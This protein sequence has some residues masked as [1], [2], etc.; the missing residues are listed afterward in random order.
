[1]SRSAVASN[2]GQCA[3]KAHQDNMFVQCLHPK[4]AVTGVLLKCKIQHTQARLKRVTCARWVRLVYVRRASLS[5][6]VSCAFGLKMFLNMSNMLK[7]FL[8]VRRVPGVW[9]IRFEYV[10]R[11]LQARYMPPI[12]RK[13]WVY[14]GIQ[15][16][17]KHRLWVLVRTASPHNHIE[18]N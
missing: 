4:I 8:E 17:P 3:G 10:P 6:R 18:Q 13:H 9:L 7:N 11:A 15:F 5:V 12:T 1:M 16:D 2:A 14:R